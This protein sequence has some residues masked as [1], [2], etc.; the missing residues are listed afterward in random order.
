[1]TSDEEYWNQRTFAEMKAAL[2]CDDP[3]IASLHVDFATRYLRKA[4]AEREQPEVRS[5]PS[6][7]LLR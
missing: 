2:S 3:R 7:S 5:T 6:A 4:L 1:M